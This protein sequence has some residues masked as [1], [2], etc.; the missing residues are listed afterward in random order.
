VRRLLVPIAL[1]AALTAAGAGSAK[2]ITGTGRSE[3]LRGTAGPDRIFGGNGND[4]LYGLDGGDL[5][6][7][8]AGADRLFGGPEDD[9]IAAQADGSADRVSCGPGRDIVDIDGRESVSPDCEVV[10]RRISRAV[11]DIGGQAQTE[12]EPDSFSWGK[13]VVAVFQVGRYADGGAAAIGWARSIGGRTWRAG[14]LPGVTPGRSNGVRVADPT[15][16]YDAKHRMW[17]AATL[18]GRDDGDDLLISRSRNGVTWRRPVVAATSDGEA[19]DKG[20]IACDSSRSSRVR[21]HCYLSYWDIPAGAIETRTSADGGLTWSSPVA[22]YGS[23]RSQGLVNGAQP[24]V[25]PDGTLVVFYVSYDG[26]FADELLA[27]RSTD[28]GASFD[29]PVLVANLEPHDVYG[30]RAPLFPSADVDAKGRLYVAWHDCSER[31]D[32]VGNDIVFATSASGV[33]WSAPRAVPTRIG[34][35]AD[36]VFL[37]GLAVRPGS[38]GNGADVAI[39]YYSRQPPCG[40][41]DCGI[42]VGLVESSNGGATWRLPQRLDAQPMRDFWIADGGIGEML[43]DYISTSWVNGRPVAVFAL[44]SAPRGRELRQAIFAARVPVSVARRRR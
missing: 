7:G 39:T 15:I 1:V 29:A 32:C 41:G 44:A 18:R 14:L 22:L 37:P 26:G 19:F 2:T 20:W 10:A 4:R 13:T 6:S 42:E 43:A 8:G 28:G 36:D 35:V 5:L 31:P 24:V 17:L 30:I 25:R 9:R 38:S 12:V 16:A 33:A 23:D 21:G 40:L 11:G 27:A 34:I 3:V